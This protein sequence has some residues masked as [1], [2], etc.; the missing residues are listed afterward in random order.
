MNI[1]ITGCAGFIGSHVTEE[2]VNNGYGVYGVDAFTYAGKKENL[3]NVMDKPNFNLT[4][5][6]ILSTELLKIIIKE[7]DIKWVIHLAAETHVDNSIKDSDVFLRTNVN[8]TKSIIDA[9]VAT[10]SKIL[11]FSTDEVYGCAFDESFVE[12]DK[13]DPRNPYSASKAAAE[14]LVTSYANTYGLKYIMVR[15]SNNFGP[16]QHSEK[17]LPTILKKIKNGDKV[18]LY[19]DGLHEREWMYVKETSKATRFILENS[20]DN[21]VY[22]VSSGFHMKNLHVIQKVCDILGVDPQ[23]C[24][25]YVKDRP[26]HDRKYS[27]DSTKLNQLGHQVLSDFDSH[28]Q[29]TIHH[30]YNGGLTWHHMTN[31]H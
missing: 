8:G 9:C 21:Q 18:P 3:K 10:G 24:V 1:M 11:H 7:N 17:F 31:I 20:K 29:E 28:I 22:N 2:F 19:G 25:E 30:T 12:S 26:G 15:P 4:E 23:D 6:N 13:L 16:R 27:I 14:H 5:C